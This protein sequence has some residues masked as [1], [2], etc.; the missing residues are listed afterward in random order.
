MSRLRIGT[1]PGLFI[2]K[3]GARGEIAHS[4][5]KSRADL[6]PPGFE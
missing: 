3:G 4:D 5:K 2:C 1:P 6:N